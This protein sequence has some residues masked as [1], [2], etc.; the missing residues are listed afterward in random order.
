MV[1]AT[2]PVIDKVWRE[3]GFVKEYG[4]TLAP[5][6][7]HWS[8]RSHLATA[9]RGTGDRPAPHSQQATAI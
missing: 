8:F 1:V 7:R 3:R 2:L 9:R 4:A 5:T 6:R